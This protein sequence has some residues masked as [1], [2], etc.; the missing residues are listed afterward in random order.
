MYLIKDN[1]IGW[2]NF[3]RLDEKLWLLKEMLGQ[4]FLQA[5][6]SEKLTTNEKKTLENRAVD[7]L[8]ERSDAV[9]RK[10]EVKTVYASK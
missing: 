7:F 5:D 8:R 9:K 2:H 10:K 3:W 4:N 6:R 1:P